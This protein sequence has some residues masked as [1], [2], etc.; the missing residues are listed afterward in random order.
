MFSIKV[1]DGN[2]MSKTG[3]L[4][5][6]IVS[7][8]TLLED[9]FEGNR[10][11]SK[12]DQTIIQNRTNLAREPSSRPQRTIW[13]LHLE[14]STSKYFGLIFRH[15]KWE[16]DLIFSVQWWVQESFWHISEVK[17]GSDATCAGEKEAES[18]I[19]PDHLEQPK[20]SEN[21]E[22]VIAALETGMLYSCV[23][24]C[25]ELLLIIF[26]IFLPF[27]KHGVL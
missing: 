23:N 2:A 27:T 20:V 21:I 13:C 5:N 25:V 26:S 24:R 18:E 17:M 1:W 9:W 16:K 7:L 10:L 6:T 12:F 3:P 8:Q 14:V 4:L 19:F 22:N 11:H 15:S